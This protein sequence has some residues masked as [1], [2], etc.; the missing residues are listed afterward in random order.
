MG[1]GF[2]A[3]AGGSL[4]WPD[5]WAGREFIESVKQKALVTTESVSAG[6]AIK[7]PQV[8]LLWVVL[9]CNVT[10]GIGILEQA[11]PMIQDF[12]REGGTSAVS[13]AAAGGFVGL[14]SIANIGSPAQL[15]QDAARRLARQLCL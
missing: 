8:W 9:F 7:T 3:P 6:N 5:G 14:L 10:A 15:V 13:A 2:G 4:K 11:A 1:H 12:F